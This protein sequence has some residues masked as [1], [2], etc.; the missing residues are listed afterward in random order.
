MSDQNP[1]LE[2]AEDRRQLA[3]TQQA[4]LSVLLPLKER[5]VPPWLLCIVLIRCARV[6]L[7]LMSKEEQAQLLPSLK[8]YLEGR[9]TR[10]GAAEDL[11]V[12][13]W[14]LPSVRKN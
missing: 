7:R 14:S 10:P 9:L 4:V 3:D 1:Q 13:P 12:P 5:G 8:G 2:N 11:I 6:L